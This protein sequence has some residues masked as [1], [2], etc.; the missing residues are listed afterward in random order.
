[1]GTFLVVLEVNGGHCWSSWG[2]FWALGV[3]LGGSWVV[4]GRLGSGV[5][6][7]YKETEKNKKQSKTRCRVLYRIPQ[8]ES[9][10]HI[11]RGKKNKEIKNISNTNNPVYRESPNENQIFDAQKRG[12]QNPGR[13]WIGFWT[14]LGCQKGPKTE[15]KT[16]KNRSKI[17]LKN[18]RVLERS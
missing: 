2:L 3:V 7:R 6:R 12:A 8:R 11:L 1:M 15:P 16:T 17:V 18:D 5:F 10:F 9:N 4:L 13:S 14:H